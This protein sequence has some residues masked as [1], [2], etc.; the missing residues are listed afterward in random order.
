GA[1]GSG[2]GAASLYF[3]P[4]PPSRP[5]ARRVWPQ[6]TF[7]Q[8]HAVG[9]LKLARYWTP[10]AAAPWYLVTTAPTGKLAC[11]SYL[12]GATTLFTEFSTKRGPQHHLQCWFNSH[13]L[14]SE[15]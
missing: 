14:Y 3:D 13:R 8:N 9:G 1:Y 6:V 7:T 5:G 12:V 2:G 4:L 10:T 15:R 11:S